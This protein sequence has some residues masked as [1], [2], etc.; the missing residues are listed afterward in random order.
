[1]SS[2]RRV[3]VTGA[4][5]FIGQSLCL[6]LSEL[7]AFEALRFTK[8]DDPHTLASLVASA[9]VV[10]HL[11]GINRPVDTNEFQT[12][13][14]DLMAQLCGYIAD[15][16]VTRE[17][18]IPIIF[19]SS[20]QAALD[21]P[22]GVSKRQAEEIL[23]A[24]HRNTGLPI[25]IYRLPGV[26]GKWCKPNYNS[27]VAT[28]CYN[29]AHDLPLAIHAPSKR[30]DLVYIDDVVNSLIE[31]LSLRAPP[32]QAAV[33]PCYEVTLAELAVLIQSFKASRRTGITARVGVGLSRALYATY[34]SY[35]ETTQF[36]Y[37]LQKNVDS[38]G[39]FVEV[40]K[41]EDSGQFSYFTAHP[42]I[43]RGGH[44]H[45]TKTEKFLV[46]R[47]TARFGFRHMVTNE[48]FE[49]TTQGVNPEVVETIPGWTHDITNIG[50]DELVVMLWAN[51]IYDRAKPDTIQCK[52]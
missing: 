3:L 50:V 45:H 24:H 10:V 38:R 47:G 23:E 5:G 33:Q 11:A 35:L 37:P 43:T 19:A 52:V 21:N 31:S 7:P 40:L 1:M 2:A 28:F 34:L 13:N 46:I 42:G 26:F 51:E 15:Q 44:Y 12:G 36:T 39:E 9:D 22:Y 49:L 20:T 17:R 4:N 27:V 32:K 30:V 25:S 16:K 6:R 14:V 41:T 8:T 29:V 48:Q 18:I